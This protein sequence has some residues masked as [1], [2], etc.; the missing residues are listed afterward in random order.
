MDKYFVRI[1]NATMVFQKVSEFEILTEEQAK[2]DIYSNP[3]SFNSGHTISVIF[4]TESV[5]LT[6]DLIQRDFDLA[7][8]MDHKIPN[9]QFE[10]I[11]TRIKEAK[12]WS[13]KLD[14]LTGI[15]GK[16]TSNIDLQELLFIFASKFNIVG[17]TIYNKGETIF[18]TPSQLCSHYS[19]IKE[20][21]LLIPQES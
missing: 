3:N 9:H 16:R 18:F 20:N 4:N 7:L 12:A 5:N 17:G 15:S 14:K 13:K 8:F 21:A 10:V 6:F 19:T 11:T 1:N 2:H